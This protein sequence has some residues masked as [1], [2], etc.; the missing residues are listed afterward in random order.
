MEG[1]GSGVLRR[2]AHRAFTLIELLV[3]IAIIAILASILLPALAGAKARARAVHCVS[4][5]RQIGV[6]CAMYVQDNN[7]ALPMSAHQRASWVGQLAAYG[8]TNTYRCPVDFNTNRISS[9]AINDFLTPQPFGAREMDF[10]RLPAIPSPAETLHLAEMEKDFEGSDHFHFADASSGGYAPASFI[11][12]VG[13]Q[14]H[15]AAANYLFADSHVEGMRWVRVKNLL[16]QPGARLVRP[17][18]HPQ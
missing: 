3:V 16:I 2:R 4:N 7:E 5:L 14:R 9:Y 1:V 13:V 15:V 17:D 10:S 18:G 6:G 8:V 12:Q 11:K